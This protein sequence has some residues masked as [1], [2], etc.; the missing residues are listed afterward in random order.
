MRVKDK[1]AIITGSG[2]GMGKATAILFAQEGAKVVVADRDFSSAEKTVAEIKNSGGQAMAIEIDVSKEKS[3][4][5]G[6][7]KAVQEFSKIDILVNCAGIN[8]VNK[9]TH[10]VEEAE[11]DAVFAVDVKGV[12][13]CSKHAIP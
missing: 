13:F 11:W 5:D 12:F 6:F 9:W 4:A 2:T 7:K 1:V 3:V 8:G 10:E